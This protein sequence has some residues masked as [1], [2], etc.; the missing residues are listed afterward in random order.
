MKCTPSRRSLVWVPFTALLFLLP[1][2]VNAQVSI[3]LPLIE[4]DKPNNEETF[5]ISSTTTTDEKLLVKGD[6]DMP[7]ATKTM[8]IGKRT[9]TREDERRTTPKNKRSEYQSTFPSH[10][11]NGQHNTKSPPARNVDEKGHHRDAKKFPREEGNIRASKEEPIE[12]HKLT[13]RG[14][15]AIAFMV[16]IVAVAVVATVVIA[17]CVTRSSQ[18]GSVA[19]EASPEEL[20][21]LSEMGLTA[22]ALGH[23]DRHPRRHP[24]V[25]RGNGFDYVKSIL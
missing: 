18:R 12:S 3:D 1:I 22:T 7:T 16:T 5:S 21:R 13:S 23:D 14:V 8:P 15:L 10:P 19:N 20:G 11:L 17:L 2:N 25:V 24:R 4:I 6:Q 9:M